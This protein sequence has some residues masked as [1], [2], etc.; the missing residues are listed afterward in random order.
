MF[1]FLKKRTNLILINFS[2]ILDKDGRRNMGDSCYHIHMPY[3]YLVYL[4]H[5]KFRSVVAGL[6]LSNQKQSSLKNF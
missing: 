1:C 4:L 2:R 3:G 5:C 6:R